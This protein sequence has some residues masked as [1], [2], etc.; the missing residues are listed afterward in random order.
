V[1]NIRMDFKR[2]FFLLFCRD[3]GCEPNTGQKSCAI[4]RGFV[5]LKCIILPR[6]MKK[7]LVRERKRC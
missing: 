1:I 3:L 6:A 2:I 7:L 4:S 5:C